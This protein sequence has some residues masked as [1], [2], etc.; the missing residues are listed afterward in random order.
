MNPDEYRALATVASQP[1]GISLHHEKWQ[2]YLVE[3]GL[4]N[5]GEL[6]DFAFFKLGVAIHLNKRRVHWQW[7][8]WLIAA[9]KRFGE[10]F[11]QLVGLFGEYKPKTI[12]DY[13]NL[14][15]RDYPLAERRWK[16]SVAHYREVRSLPPEARNA[17]MTLAQ[18]HGWG[19]SITLREEVQKL[20]GFLQNIP[21]TANEMTEDFEEEGG[22]V[23]DVACLDGKRNLDPSATLLDISGDKA[24]IANALAQVMQQIE[25][26]PYGFY[27]VHLQIEK[28]GDM[29]LDNRS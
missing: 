2:P 24:K 12:Q 28:T 25:Y 14:G 15:T 29:V 19:S 1:G 7:I 8:D 9:E 6:D 10:N 22:G 16:L 17:L 23:M 3:M 13:L 4:V 20:R 27:T 18:E 11:Y 26:L 5:T 21:P